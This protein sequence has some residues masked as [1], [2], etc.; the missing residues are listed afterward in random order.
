[1]TGKLF[2][3][4]NLLKVSTGRDFGALEGLTSSLLETFVGD[5]LLEVSIRR[6]FRAL[7]GLRETRHSEN[8]LAKKGY[9]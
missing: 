1:M 3:G 8:C 7:Q 5:K 6:D 9:T 2:L 4:T